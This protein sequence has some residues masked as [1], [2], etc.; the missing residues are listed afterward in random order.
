MK[1]VTICN[2][3]PP[4]GGAESFARSLA[5]FLQKSGDMVTVVTHRMFQIQIFEDN[6][7]R[8]YPLD[9]DEQL[10]LREHDIKIFP[11][12]NCTWAKD[13]QS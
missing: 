1:I 3:P 10:M 5:L 8:E 9:L 4:F 2:L 7:L 11:A 13:E 6:G 12:F